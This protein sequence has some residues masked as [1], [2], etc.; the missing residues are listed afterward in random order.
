MITTSQGELFAFFVGV[1]V[2]VAAI[3]TLLAKPRSEETRLAELARAM[4]QI[5]EQVHTRNVRNAQWAVMP[6]RKKALYVGGAILFMG[7]PIWGLA[8]FVPYFVHLP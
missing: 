6:S 5:R 8:V 4:P 2:I 3:G 1:L 7:W